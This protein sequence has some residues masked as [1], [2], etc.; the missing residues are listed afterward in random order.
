MSYKDQEQ[1]RLRLLEQPLLHLPGITEW[2]ACTGTQSSPY[3][4]IYG[5]IDAA[6]SLAQ[7]VVKNEQHGK[8]DTLIMPV[9]FCVRH[10]IEL[11]LKF[12][13]AELHRTRHLHTPPEKHHNLNRLLNQILS[14]N[15]KDEGLRQ[16]ITKIVPYIEDIS[17]IDNIGDEFRYFINSSGKISLENTSLV[18]YIT[19]NRSIP[20]LK[21]V[22]DELIFGIRE[23]ADG[24]KTGSFTKECSRRDLE[25]IARML[26]LRRD[27]SSS[28]FLEKREEIKTR[29]HLSSNA[30]SRALNV[31]Q[32]VRWLKSIIGVETPPLAITKE[33]ALFV[34]RQWLRYAKFE[35]SVDDPFSDDY[36]KLVYSINN[37]AKCALSNE[38]L[39]DV[40]AIFTIARNQEFPEFYEP[41]FEELSGLNAPPILSAMFENINFMTYF[42]DGLKMIGATRLAADVRNE[43]GVLGIPK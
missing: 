30:F 11:T 14:S 28:I 15:L 6:I 38:A 4:Y 37:S 25:I 39:F 24:I 8:R 33:N 32:N 2:N 5:Y 10:G 34:T 26:P 19:L 27:W 20:Y 40:E 18:N 35:S 41:L 3:N 17:R 12:I 13:L 9:L 31:I 42:S 22:I 36:L 43:A 23:Y 16:S 7:N 21:E 29:F 1:Y